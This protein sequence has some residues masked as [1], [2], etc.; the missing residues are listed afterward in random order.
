MILVIET[1]FDLKKA[2]LR[3]F[4]LSRYVGCSVAW[5]KIEFGIQLLKFLLDISYFVCNLLWV[6]KISSRYSHELIS[7]KHLP[8]AV[9]PVTGGK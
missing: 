2:A 5:K 1:N 8:G 4:L 9:N 3:A 7:R 6:M